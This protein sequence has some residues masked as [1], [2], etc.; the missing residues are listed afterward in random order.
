MTMAQLKISQGL[1]APFKL[2]MEREF[3][4]KVIRFRFN[5]GEINI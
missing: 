4:Q 1:Y 3:A 2:S 5:L